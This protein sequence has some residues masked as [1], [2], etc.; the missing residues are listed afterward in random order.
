VDCPTRSI[1]PRAARADERN[2]LRARRDLRRL[3]RRSAKC[4]L[5]DRAH[6]RRRSGGSCGRDRPRCRPAVELARA[7]ANSAKAPN[8][9][10]LV[11]PRPCEPHL[12]ASP[13]HA[14]AKATLLWS[15]SPRASRALVWSRGM[16]RF[17]SRTSFTAM[18]KS[19]SRL[20]HGATT[21]QR[22]IRSPLAN[23]ELARERDGGGPESSVQHLGVTDGVPAAMR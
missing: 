19:G 5:A 15:I 1:R 9:V 8:S 4:R 3:G 11:D 14:R 7:P 16:P 23:V 21:S 10:V 18:T 22:Q 17:R 6:R 12:V 13:R 20:S 2:R